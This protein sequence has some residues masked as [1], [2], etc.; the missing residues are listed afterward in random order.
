[1]A[2]ALGRDM[3]FMDQIVIVLTTVVASIGAGCIPSG[4][5]R[6]APP[7]LRGRGPARRADPPAADDRLVPGPMPDDLERPGRH[8]RR[9]PPGSDRD[10]RRAGGRGVGGLTKSSHLL[11]QGRRRRPFRTDRRRR[12]RLRPGDRPQGRPPGRNDP[13]GRPDDLA[14]YLRTRDR[15]AGHRPGPAAVGAMKCCQRGSVG[16]APPMTRSS[17]RRKAPVRH[18]CLTNCHPV[19]IVEVKDVR[20]HPTDGGRGDD[21]R[22]IPRKMDAPT[23]FPG[24]KKPD[25]ATGPGVET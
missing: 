24:M 3:S 23:I 21:S 9:R 2:Q 12:L 22:A 16:N 25:D 5:L 6:H 11:P 18:Q 7:D 19:E 20:C 10:P 17:I 15:M 8:D 4:E 1:M 14:K 13:S